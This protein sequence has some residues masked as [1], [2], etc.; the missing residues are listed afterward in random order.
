[1]VAVTSTS[2]VAKKTRGSK[3]VG[4]NRAYS[5]RGSEKN[6]CNYGIPKSVDKVYV[7]QPICYRY[8]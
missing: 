4:L 1:M 6:E 2:S 7:L 8:K 3:I 5:N